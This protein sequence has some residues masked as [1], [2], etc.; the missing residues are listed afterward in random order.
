MVELAA[1]GYLLL[2]QIRVSKFGKHI[3]GMGGPLQLPVAPP[4]PPKV[5]RI[6]LNIPSPLPLPP[7]PCLARRSAASA[8]R[9]RILGDVSAAD[10]DG[11]G[12]WLVE[13]C[14]LLDGKLPGTDC[15]LLMS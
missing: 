9:L 2:I 11:R 7:S 8:V 15:G 14:G 6:R 3:R 5:S 1:Q 13:G 12:D 4:D 10:D